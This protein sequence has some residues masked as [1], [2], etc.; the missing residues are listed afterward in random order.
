MWS[1]AALAAEAADDAPRA[2][3]IAVPRLATVGIS[4]SLYQASSPITSE[5]LRPSA[6]ALVQSANMVGEW[7]PQTTNFLIASTDTPAFWANCV[8]AR[9]WSSR[10]IAVMFSVGKSLA[11]AARIIALVLA[12]L[13]TTITLAS[14]LAPSFRASPCTRKISALALRRSRRSMPCVR[15]REPTKKPASMSRKAAFG[16]SVMTTSCSSGKAQSS[17]SMTTPFTAFWAWGRSR[18][19]SATGVSLP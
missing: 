13:P 5:S 10:S 11:L 6:V 18:S 17:S 2:S 4:V 3:M 8:S 14:R 7:L 19:C 9:L 1:I 15:G 12:G 16:S